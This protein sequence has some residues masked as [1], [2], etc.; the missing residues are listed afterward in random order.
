MRINPS[1]AD[2]QGLESGLRHVF[3]PNGAMTVHAMHQRPASK[4][5]EELRRC[6]L[7]VVSTPLCISGMP[8]SNPYAMHSTSS[9]GLWTFQEPWA[10]AY[11]Q[12][13]RQEG[14]THSMAV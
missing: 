7:R 3:W 10:Q 2:S 6:P 8:A 5:W 11:Y 9:L 1:S 4:R 13:K 12:R 14:K